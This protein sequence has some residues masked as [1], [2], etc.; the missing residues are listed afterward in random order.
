[1]SPEVVNALVHLVASAKRLR[2]DDAAT[3]N[4]LIDMG[5]PKEHA[6]DLLSD[7][8]TGLDQG[9][10]VAAL[11]FGERPTSPPASPLLVAAFA[12]GHRTV[13]IERRW[14]ARMKFILFVVVAVVCCLIYY[15]TR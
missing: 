5:V 6:S 2:V 12:E 10:T 8:R 13:L 3:I 14:A 15:F 7:I 9:A 4:R 1:M 11:G